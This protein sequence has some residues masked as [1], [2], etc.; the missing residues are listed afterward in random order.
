MF[1]TSLLL[2]THSKT[3]CNSLLRVSVT[4]LAVVGDVYMVES[5]SYMDTH[6][7]FNTSGRSL[8][9]IEKRA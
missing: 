4:S 7:L 5:S 6:A 2:A 3:D 8:A 9:K 1:R